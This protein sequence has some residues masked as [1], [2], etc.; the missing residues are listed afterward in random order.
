MNDLM[1]KRIALMKRKKFR[2]YVRT[3][4]GY[5]LK[6]T[7]CMED[8]AISFKIT[9]SSGGV[10]DKTANLFDIY[11]SQGCTSNYGLITN[12]IKDDEII[13]ETTAQAR[14]G[15]LRLGEFEPGTY[16]IGASMGWVCLGNPLTDTVPSSGFVNKTYTIKSKTEI[17]L[18]VSIT[19]EQPA[20][21]KN[22]Q[23]TLSDTATEY[24][25]YGYRIPIVI[26]GANN[27]SAIIREYIQTPI[28]DG[29][30][31]DITAQIPLYRGENTV[32]VQTSVAPSN[33]EMSYYADKEE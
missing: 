30:S 21:I 8:T 10:G 20:A 22:I 33:T 1:L 31:V 9:G 11:S 29:E 27:N 3:A 25:R 15:F 23:I 2:G 14:S 19:K 32:T 7:D 26:E 28:E 13:A 24:E 6:L 5:P 18:G 4:S 16:Y 12:I 17:F